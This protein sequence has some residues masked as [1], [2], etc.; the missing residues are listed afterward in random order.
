VAGGPI[1]GGF[2]T[3]PGNPCFGFKSPPPLGEAVH[4]AFFS[5]ASLDLKGKNPGARAAK[6]KIKMIGR[7]EMRITL[8]GKNQRGNNWMLI[9]SLA[10]VNC[11]IKSDS[12]DVNEIFFADGAETFPK[13]WRDQQIQ[14]RKNEKMKNLLAVGVGL[15]FLSAVG[16]S[17]ADDA[18]LQTDKNNQQ[19]QVN[20]DQHNL[21]S[22]NDKMD[23]DQSAINGHND[24]INN[25]KKE[26]SKDS[27]SLKKQRARRAKRLAALKKERDKNRQITKSLD[28]SKQ[29]LQKT[30]EKIEDKKQDAAAK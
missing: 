4:L 3:E 21:N 14:K 8:I 22:S 2:Q 18:A 1:R 25:D 20:V 26:I 16:I 6:K 7:R 27:V 11:R 13:E 15:L 5:I 10:L 17:R 9:L 23:A 30:D 12:V 28:D 19:H 24:K 29:N